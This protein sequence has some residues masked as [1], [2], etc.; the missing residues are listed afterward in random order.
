MIST[1]SF[2]N[3]MSFIDVVITT[4]FDA[5]LAATNTLLTDAYGVGVTSYSVYDAWDGKLNGH[6]HRIY[7]YPGMDPE[8]SV[9][10]R[11]MLNESRYKLCNKW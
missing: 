5:N 2:T 3:C 8:N 4:N 11:Y 7:E 9:T 10:V 6:L 1:Q